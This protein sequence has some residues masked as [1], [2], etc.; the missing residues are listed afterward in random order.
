VAALAGA[1]TEGEAP[2]VVGGAEP[3]GQRVDLLDGELELESRH[4]YGRVSIIAATIS[5]MPKR[6]MILTRWSE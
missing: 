5:A 4:G 6:P 2:E 3:A 1:G